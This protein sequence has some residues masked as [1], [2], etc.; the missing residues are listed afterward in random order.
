M[1]LLSYAGEKNNTAHPPG[2]YLFFGVDEL[3]EVFG[4]VSVTI[5][6]PFIP[7]SADGKSVTAE[8]LQ[9]FSVALKYVAPELV[10]V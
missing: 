2:Q 8:E 10:Q 3:E 5:P 4:F 6:D 1:V 7:A 9:A